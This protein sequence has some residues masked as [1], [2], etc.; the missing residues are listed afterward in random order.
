MKLNVGDDTQTIK[1][2]SSINRLNELVKKGKQE[3]YKAN[4]LY[5]HTIW[6]VIIGA[7]ENEESYKRDFWSGETK[8]GKGENILSL[9]PPPPQGVKELVGGRT[10]LKECSHFIC[11]PL[12]NTVESQTALQHPSFL[13]RHEGERRWA[14]SST[15]GAM[16]SCYQLR[17][18]IK[19]A[20][21]LQTEDR[22]IP[23][24]RGGGFGKRLEI[25][26][27]DEWEGRNHTKQEVSAENVDAILGHS[28]D[29][30]AKDDLDSLRLSMELKQS[31]SL[32]IV[33]QSRERALL[34]LC[35]WILRWSTKRQKLL[36]FVVEKRGIFYCRL[37][38]WKMWETTAVRRQRVKGEVILHWQR[39]TASRLAQHAQLS[40]FLSGLRNRAYASSRVMCQRLFRFWRVW[41]YRLYSRNCYREQT[42]AAEQF[43][44]QDKHVKTVI[45]TTAVREEETNGYGKPPQFH[46]EKKE[47]NSG[48]VDPSIPVKRCYKRA[49][50]CSAYYLDSEDNADLLACTSLWRT[51]SR[52][53][54]PFLCI[55]SAAASHAIMASSKLFSSSTS[56][57]LPKMFLYHPHYHD[58]ILSKTSFRP[59][60]QTLGVTKALFFYWKKRVERHLSSLLGDW[61]ARERQIFVALDRWKSRY[62]AATE[63]GAI[64]DCL[65]AKN[66][67]KDKMKEEEGE[68]EKSFVM[69]TEIRDTARNRQTLGRRV[70]LPQ[71]SGSE[72]PIISAKFSCHYKLKILTEAHS[73]STRQWAFDRWQKRFILRQGDWFYLHSLQSKVLR[74]WRT[75]LRYHMWVNC[76]RRE[77]WSWWRRR[78]QVREAG[79]VAR[80]WHQ[81][82]LLY[83][84]W[85]L[86]NCESTIQSQNRRNGLR[87]CIDRWKSRFLR[88]RWNP[89]GRVWLLQHNVLKLWQSRAKEVR[90]RRATM[91]LADSIH[92]TVMLIFLFHRWRKLKQK[93]DRVNLK[94][95]VLTDLHDEKLRKDCFYRWKRYMLYPK[96]DLT[97]GR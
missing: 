3:Y 46:I 45:S 47:E 51:V 35:F 24:K 54:Y 91:L 80:C 33:E 4:L 85:V 89:N 44:L 96:K 76:Q 18:E 71:R 69:L 84:C 97:V 56:W 78:V 17:K 38:I 6:K 81:Q 22:K 90:Q 49:S 55:Q 62:I 27:T 53:E 43:R 16:K 77:W 61:I 70:L 66:D 19:D 48:F 26:A 87:W 88:R 40:G 72:G 52:E 68:G 74:R 95:R 93:K 23:S 39:Y 2:F 12:V 86:W 31:V 63:D 10:L 83:R 21:L 59:F 42:I 28:S 37:Q 36:R 9:P 14:C 67:R 64:Q 79:R 8:R 34:R 7:K 94:L 32:L 75:A 73:F 1:E 65:Q 60:L 29:S 5:L 50:I 57:G 30:E 92:K 82:N 41:V 13:T 58:V 15:V 20:L 11:S 25:G